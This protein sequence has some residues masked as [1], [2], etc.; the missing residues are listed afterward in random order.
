MT[1]TALAAAAALFLTA[2][3]GFAA[4][5]AMA[6]CKDKCCCEAMKAKADKADK[7]AADPHAGRHDHG[8]EPAKPKA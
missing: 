2:G 1:R 7:P 8:A 5:C 6:C 4:E 3:A